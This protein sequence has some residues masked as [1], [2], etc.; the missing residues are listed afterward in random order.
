MKKPRVLPLFFYFTC[1]M[2]LFLLA[3]G[4]AEDMESE[5]SLSLNPTNPTDTLDSTTESTGE[6]DAF[7]FRV[8]DIYAQLQAKTR[9]V[10]K[11]PE[12]VEDPALRAAYTR[13]LLSKGKLALPH[14]W[15]HTEDAVL[16]AEYYRAQ[17]RKQFGNMPQVQIVANWELKQAIAST[18]EMPWFQIKAGEHIAYL[19]ALYH[20]W[21]TET[22]RRALED[23]RKIEAEPTY[24][25][26]RE[27]NPE[28]WAQ[29]ERELLIEEYGDKPQTHVV[30]DF[31]RKLALDL[32]TTEAEYLAY[33]EALVHLKPDDEVGKRLLERFRQAKAD[34]IPFKDVKVDDIVPPEE[35]VDE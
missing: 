2:A 29:R 22:H 10:P 33:L 8:E 27:K 14:H 26:L 21:P 20:L 1:L 25:E 3:C 9:T 23:A 6:L 18:M 12:K 24:E 13:F 28:L 15:V 4:D 16:R 5:T 35:E 19:E 17:L 32:H 11:N 30:A 31:H 34:G 7:I